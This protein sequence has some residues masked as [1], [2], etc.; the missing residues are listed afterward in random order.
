[1]TTVE[2]FGNLRLAIFRDHNPPHFHVLGHGCSI[3][4]DLRTF[5]IME[6]RPVP[7]GAIPVIAWARANA[8]LLWQFWNELNG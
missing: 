7:A 3:S 4:V 5:E 8:D 2:R 1:M 6:G